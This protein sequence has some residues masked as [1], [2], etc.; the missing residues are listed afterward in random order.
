M[1]PTWLTRSII[2]TVATIAALSVGWS[3]GCMG[4]SIAQN[5]YGDSKSCENHEDRAIQVMMALLATLI[6]LRSNPPT[7]DDP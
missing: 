1:T 2:A 7:A 3:V 6:S 4:A 5:P